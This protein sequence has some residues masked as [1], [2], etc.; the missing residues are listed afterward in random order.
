MASL[1][2]PN[3]ALKPGQELSPR[4]FE[5][6]MRKLQENFDYIAQRLK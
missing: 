6:L 2:H 5:E 3:I 1:P 4:E